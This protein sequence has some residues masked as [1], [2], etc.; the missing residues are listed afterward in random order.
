LKLKKPGLN[1]LIL[2]KGCLVN[3]VVP[4][5]DEH[6]FFFKLLN[7]FEIGESALHFKTI[8]KPARA[9]AL[10]YYRRVLFELGI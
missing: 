5:S 6:D 4:L 2:E 10:E 3:F 8:P 1:Y 7:D 9:E